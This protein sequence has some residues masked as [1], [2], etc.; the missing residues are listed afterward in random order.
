MKTTSK[1]TAKTAKITDFSAIE[2]PFKILASET[3]SGKP[4]L[5][6][7]TDLRLSTEDFKALN[8]DIQTAGGYGFM[9]FYPELKGRFLSATKVDRTTLESLANQY[10]WKKAE[11]KEKTKKTGKT[12]NNKT[13]KAK[14]AAI[15]DI[16][17]E[18]FA[19]FQQFQAMLAGNK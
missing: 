14:Q 8:L 13:E 10:V 7:V 12:A 19:K 16:D 2:K 11:P 18:L 6:L 5:V 15:A 1:N 3:N 4:C 17:P 9:K